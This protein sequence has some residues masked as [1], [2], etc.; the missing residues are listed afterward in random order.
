MLCLAG[1]SLACPVPLCVWLIRGCHMVRLWL[2]YSQGGYVMFS[3]SDCCLSCAVLHVALPWL[4]CG[5]VA[6]CVQ[7]EMMILQD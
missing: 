5:G 1:L 4:S 2:V 7:S 6:V 3:C